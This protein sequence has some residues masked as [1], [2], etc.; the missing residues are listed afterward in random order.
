MMLPHCSTALRVT[1]RF[2]N[3]AMFAMLD[4]ICLETPTSLRIPHVGSSQVGKFI[5]DQAIAIGNEVAKASGHLFDCLLFFVGVC[6]CVFSALLGIA[7][8]HM[9]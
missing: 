3:L 7:N 2:L 5:A 6:V 9:T 8:G 4:S 1:V